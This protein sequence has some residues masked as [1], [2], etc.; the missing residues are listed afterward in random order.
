MVARIPGKWNYMQ[1]LGF[2]FWCTMYH[3]QAPLLTSAVI[4]IREGLLMAWKI[5]ILITKGC[6]LF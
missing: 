5:A 2:L 4:R 6:F 3:S 1:Y